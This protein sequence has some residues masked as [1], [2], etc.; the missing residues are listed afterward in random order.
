MAIV[1][2]TPFKHNI[3]INGV[4]YTSAFNEGQFSTTPF[5]EG[6]GLILLTGQITLGQNDINLDPRS[7]R[8]LLPGVLVTIT[9]N[10]GAESIPI[11]GHM[12]IS[13]AQYD[14][15]S[16][17]GTITLACWLALTNAASRAEIGVCVEDPEDGVT[18]QSAIRTLLEAAGIPPANID[19]SNIT[20]TLLESKQINEGTSFVRCAGELAYSQGFTLYMSNAGIVSAQV[21]NVRDT[22]PSPVVAIQEI[23]LA[24]YVQKADATVSPF[25]KVRVNGNRLWPVRP[26]TALNRETFTNDTFGLV[27]E[28]FART[29]DNDTRVA[30]QTEQTVGPLGSVTTDFGGETLRLVLNNTTITETHELRPDPWSCDI[31]DEGRM[32]TRITSTL[33]P[34]SV[35][36]NEYLLLE[37]E[38]AEQDPRD[39]GP[40]IATTNSNYSEEF[41]EYSTPD[42]APLCGTLLLD[43]FGDVLESENLPESLIT[44]GIYFIKKT[45]TRFEP[46][47]AIFPDIAD[48]KLKRDPDIEGAELITNRFFLRPS[49]S[50]ETLWTLNPDGQTWLRVSKFKRAQWRHKPEAVRSIRDLLNNAGNYA[51]NL[52]SVLEAAVRLVDT[53]VEVDKNTTPQ[54]PGRWPSTTRYGRTPYKIDA[55]I[56]GVPAP[57]GSRVRNFNLPDETPLADVETNAAT[58][59]FREWGRTNAYLINMAEESLPSNFVPFGNIQVTEVDGNTYLYEADAINLSM[60]PNLAFYASIGLLIGKD[61]GSGNFQDVWSAGCAW[62]TG[63]SMTDSWLIAEITDDCTVIQPGWLTMTDSVTG[64]LE[65][66][67]E[68]LDQILAAD[69]ESCF[70]YNHLP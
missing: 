7:N 54:E 34:Q 58:I 2:L 39:A 35:V 32:L 23:D 60:V 29:Y 21:S 69:G 22:K 27:E 68:F 26:R 67:R 46:T 4:D 31:A 10:D 37:A 30:T 20:G 45:L 47:G 24:Q 33:A 14:R 6:E 49:E 61:D 40:S 11:F 51:Y 43:E 41:W 44:T 55:C 56:E 3:T 65:V 28:Y 38:I 36:L 15:Q 53:V 63:M 70:L 57:I 18:M 64:E 17:R 1:N 48:P 19:V 59:L 12:Y 9:R 52:S 16:D 62:N 50:E 66:D 25:G 13:G 42:N 5:T 8:D